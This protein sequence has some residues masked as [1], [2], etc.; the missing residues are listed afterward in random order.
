MKKNIFI[1]IFTG[2]LANALGILLYILIFSDKGI[3]ATITKA[4]AEGYLGKIISLGAVLNLVAFFIFIK[5]NQN[6]KARGV[7][8]ATISIAVVTAFLMFN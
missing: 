6:Y 5:K 4:L 7:L 3:D 8:L 1:G 2:I